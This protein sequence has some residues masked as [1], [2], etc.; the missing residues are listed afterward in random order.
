MASA[1]HVRHKGDG[2]T[3]AP[4][5]EWKLVSMVEDRNPMQYKFRS[6]LWN[7]KAI[8][9]LI[10][11]LFGLHMPL[12]TVRLYVQRNGFTPQR[13]DKLAN[14]GPRIRSANLTAYMRATLG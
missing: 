10:R 9:E 11:A 13:P 5:Q 6:A 3:L 14:I 4:E 12:R 2:R 7:A 1:R 8:R